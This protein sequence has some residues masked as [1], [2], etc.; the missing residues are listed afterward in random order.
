MTTVAGRKSRDLNWRV[1]AAGPG[2]GRGFRSCRVHGVADC[3]VD[4]SVQALL[5]AV[6]VAPFVAEIRREPQ[7]RRHGDEQ[8][9]A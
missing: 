5:E 8:E 2:R 7:R 6:E 1:P 3:G 4:A 9:P